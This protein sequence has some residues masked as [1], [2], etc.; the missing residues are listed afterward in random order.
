[1]TVFC[2]EYVIKRTNRTG[3]LTGA[4]LGMAAA[5]AISFVVLEEQCKN[6]ELICEEALCPQRKGPSIP[7]EASRHCPEREINV[8]I[9]YE[10]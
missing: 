6:A 4:V 10:R 7:L 2:T 1:M 8:R 9:H 5:T 3:L